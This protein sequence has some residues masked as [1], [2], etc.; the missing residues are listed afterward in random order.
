MLVGGDGIP[1]KRTPAQ[2]P[3]EISENGLLVDDPGHPLDLTSA[4]RRIFSLVFGEQA[5]TFWNEIE[6][7][8]APTGQDLRG[9]I[10]A[11]AFELHL[12]QYSRSRRK[13]PVIWQ[14]GLPSGHYSVWLYAHRLGRDSVIQIQNDITG[15]KVAHEERQLTSLMESAGKNPTARE[16][17]EI[18]AQRTFVE[19]L[20]D[21]HDEVKRAANVWHPTLDD[22]V[23]L[24]MAP[25]LRLVPQNRGWQREL[26]AK[27]GELVNGKYE[28]AKLAMH[29]WPERVIPLCATDRSLAI[30][31][32]LEEN[33]W[34]ENEDG[35]WESYE[36]PKK[37]IVAL[38]RERTSNVVKAAIKNLLEAPDAAGGAKRARKSKA[39]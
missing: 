33:F 4:V 34:F 12:K 11:N 17:R 1:L 18:D 31:H 22:G 27:W 2:Y 32:G 38:I 26:R 3:L 21:L 10:S 23:V 19:E 35:K 8:L 5:D 28:W 7:V 36:K 24:T 20:R 39:A 29:L 37:S 6:H 25:L 13:S 9:W 15:P 14:F 30:A 16:V